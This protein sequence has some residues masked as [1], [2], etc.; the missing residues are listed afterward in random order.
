MT[1]SSVS[2][3]LVNETLAA[4]LYFILCNPSYL[5]NGAGVEGTYQ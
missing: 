5:R 4:S 2:E 3:G 1:I